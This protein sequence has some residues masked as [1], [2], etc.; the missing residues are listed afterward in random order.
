MVEGLWLVIKGCDGLWL[1]VGRGALF[2]SDG[3][4]NQV[5]K[6]YRF[7]F[8]MPS[9]PFRVILASQQVASRFVSKHREQELSLCSLRHEQTE[10]ARPF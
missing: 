3:P 1:L 7:E 4:C 9:Q 6:L 10:R 5:S 8:A 2:G